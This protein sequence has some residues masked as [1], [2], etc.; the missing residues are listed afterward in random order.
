MTSLGLND[1]V[2]TLYKLYPIEIIGNSTLF[3]SYKITC[4]TSEFNRIGLPV[5]IEKKPEIE[6]IEPKFRSLVNFRKGGANKQ[7]NINFIGKNQ[8]DK[9]TKSGGILNAKFCN[10]REM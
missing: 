7:G 8:I 5:A 9:N 4:I 10:K 1:I 6:K 2:P 3:I